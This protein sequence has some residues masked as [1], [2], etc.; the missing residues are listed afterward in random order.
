MS[1]SAF[2][3]QAGGL[4]G[5]F[6]E[7]IAPGAGTA[8]DDAHRQVKKAIPPYKALEE[9][10]THVV[11]ETMVQMYAPILEQMII[12]SR[13]DAL[14]GGVQ[15]I[16]PQIRESLTG[17]I[18]EATMDRA[19]FRVFGGGDFT[20]QHA[21][22]KYGEALAITL[23]HVIMFKTAEDANYNPTLWAHE[24][25]HVR[26][27]ADWGIKDFAIRYLR[28]YHS[29]EKPGYEAET[30]YVAW[31]GM[32]SAASL[33]SK[34]IEVNS[35]TI[36]QV[37]MSG[38]GDTQSSICGTALGRCQLNGSGPVGTPCWCG[39]PLGAAVGAL[40]PSVTPVALG[41][42]PTTP[43]TPPTMGNACVTPAGPCIL[44]APLIVGSSCMCMVPGGAFAGAVQMRGFG[45]VCSTNLGMCALGQPLLSGSNCACPSAYGLVGGM[46]P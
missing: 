36:N 19:V 41:S 42:D 29:V 13:N 44:N 45:G 7:N 28:S 39:T 16:P 43:P 15:P 31:S 24:L 5:D 12:A 11:K 33:A 21:S 1:F 25:T 40:V 4:I 30:R 46:V 18:D 35:D 2:N 20:L 6:V 9:G 27:F 26:Q 14:N 17:F 8:L 23:D 37:P 10:A 3:A 38:F 32:R 22:I 34:G